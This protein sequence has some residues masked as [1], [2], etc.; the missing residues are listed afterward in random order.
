VNDNAKRPNTQFAR[1]GTLSIVATENDRV[2]PCGPDFLMKRGPGDD[3]MH[4]VGLAVVE[5]GPLSSVFQS[6]EPIATA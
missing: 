3:H 4:R 1:E 5:R 2:A 6:G